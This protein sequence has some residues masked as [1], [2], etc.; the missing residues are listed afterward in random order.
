[1]YRSFIYTIYYND[2]SGKIERF[3]CEPNLESD[4]KILRIKLASEIKTGRGTWILN[5]N[6]LGNENYVNEI[7]RTIKSYK[8]NKDDYPNNKITWDILKMEIRSISTFYSTKLARKDREQFKKVE[9]ELE[10]LQNFEENQ[11]TQNIREDRFL[12]IRGK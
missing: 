1:M 9:Q 6:L 2:I 11:I 12:E 8:T 5:N 4:H 3:E 10:I 7:R